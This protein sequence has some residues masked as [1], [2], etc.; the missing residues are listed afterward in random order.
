MIFIDIVGNIIVFRVEIVPW[1]IASTILSAHAA[2]Y[3]RSVSLQNFLLQNLIVS[4]N[5]QLLK[6]FAIYFN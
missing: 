3:A 5:L 1:M 6:S 4:I 2:H